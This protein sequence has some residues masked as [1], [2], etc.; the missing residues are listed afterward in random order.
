MEVYSPPSYPS[1]T[2]PSIFLGGSIEM[3]KAVDWQRAVIERFKETDAMILNPRRDDWDSSWV[4]S[5]EN[6]QFNQQV[7]WELDY[8]HRVD[9]RIF[10]FA[11]NTLS[12]I[13]LLEFGTF[14]KWK[15]TF[16]CWDDGY[17]RK[18][19]L[20]VYCHANEIVPYHSLEQII[21]K[22]KKRI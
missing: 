4:Q 18:G 13:T 14:H 20:E 1:L 3:G 9:Y 11:G 2:K 21:D 8:L 17:L 12:P 22:I 5:I 7:R 15:N 10:Y 6:A 19:N 16:V